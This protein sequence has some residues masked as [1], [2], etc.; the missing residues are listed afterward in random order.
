MLRSSL[1]PTVLTI[2]GKSIKVRS[3]KLG[4]KTSISTMSYDT[5]FPSE[6]LRIN[7]YASI[8]ASFINSRFLIS[9]Y[10]NY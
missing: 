2:P 4:P 10:S 8:I 9:I 3:M 6:F 5:S 1:S 7:S